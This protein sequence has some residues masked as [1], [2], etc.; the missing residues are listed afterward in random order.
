MEFLIDILIDCVHDTWA[1]LPLLFITYCII[2]VFE[3]KQTSASDE[4]IFFG[5][6]RFGPLIGALVGLIP[7]CGF[8][9]LAAMLFVQRNITLGTL[10]AVMIATSDEAIPILLS[11]PELYSTLGFVLIGK[12]VTG[13]VVGYLVDFLLRNHQHIIRFAPPLVITEEL[14][15]EGLEI[16][17][18]SIKSIESV[19]LQRELLQ[20]NQYGMRWM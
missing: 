17:E 6:Q 2:E 7:Q 13:I 9:V 15:N 10:V 12:F 20:V 18:K 5:L 14:L 3:R 19:L 1:M 8:S 11:N 4:K 16:I